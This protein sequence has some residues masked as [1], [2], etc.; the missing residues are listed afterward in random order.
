MS[1]K[2]RDATRTERDSLGERKVPAEAYWGIQTLRATENFPISGR[3][4][5]PALVRAMALIKKATARANGELGG[6][7]KDVADAVEKAADEVLGG[8]LADQF[9]VDVYQA[10]AGT[11]FHMNVNEVLANRACEILDSTKGDYKRVNPN[12]HVNRGQ[13]TNDVIPTAMRL[14]LI[15]VW[16]S[17]VDATSGVAATLRLK[18][19]S[20]RDI[21]KVGRTHL[22]DA[23][24]ITLGQEVGGWATV[25]EE[26]SEH[27]RSEESRFYK[28]GLGG[29]AAG[30]ELNTLPGYRRR[31]VELLAEWTGRPLTPHPDPF[32]SMQSLADFVSAASALRELAVEATRL[33]N[34]LRL[35]SSGPRTGIAE[36]KLP[37]VQP[38][39][40]IMPGKVNP[41][42]AEMLNM[43]SFHVQGHCHT[44]DLAS[45][46]GQLELN[47]MM[48]V[49][50]HALLEA[51]SIMTNA[52][53]V[54][55]DRCLEGLEADEGRC[56][57]SA[58]ATLATATSLTPSIGYLKAAALA[59]EALET[60]K[61]LRQVVEASGLLPPEEVDRL[62]D[63]LKL[64]HPL[65]DEK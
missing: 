20:F 22:Q 27:L 36:L 64:A 24:P 55:K 59:K 62:L 51:A 33:A 18:A 45:Q 28:L 6:V 12:D 29:S 3:T 11:S 58:E 34:D 23:V 60:G 43:V 13:S 52:L 7:P 4:A 46:A 44:V 30:T 41:V 17:L 61:T 56:T 31:A 54:V 37:A 35:L 63:P 2:G 16:P 42:I 53:R 57:A 39:S 10:G 1:R 65:E 49:V 21:V 14:A 26:Q 5:H 38:G 8:K 50:I 19:D 48:P 15:D 47:V 32:A 40:S 25:F 9:V